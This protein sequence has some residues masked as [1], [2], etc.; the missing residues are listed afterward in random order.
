MIQVTEI[1]AEIEER[2]NALADLRLRI[3]GLETKR[4]ELDAIQYSPRTTTDDAKAAEADKAQISQE[5]RT[6]SQGLRTLEI[7]VSALQQE[8]RETA[9]LES[10]RAWEDLTPAMLDVE[11]KKLI[12]DAKEAGAKGAVLHLRTL[13]LDA[14]ITELKASLDHLEGLKE[15]LADKRALHVCEKAAAI[16]SGDVSRPS[17]EDISN[18]TKLETEVI[19]LERKLRD[20]PD[21]IKELE[22]LRLE[23]LEEETVAHKCKEEIK[24][25]LWAVNKK[26]ALKKYEAAIGALLDSIAEVKACDEPLNSDTAARLLEGVQS[27]GFK[28]CAATGGITIREGNTSPICASESEIKAR[29]LRDFE[30]ALRG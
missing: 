25:K 28:L 26:V 14:R 13:P 8:R 7:Q 4:G 2:S 11:R 5:I 6:L 9:S 18:L 21:V 15:D 3:K 10:E 1:Q 16:A 20:A 12:K 22:H 29:L 24:L 19:T 17:L 23:K 30:L 27:Y